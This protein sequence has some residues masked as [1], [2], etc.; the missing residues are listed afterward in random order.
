MDGTMI[1]MWVKQ[2]HQPSPSHHH[3]FI[4]GI[5][6]PFPVMGGRHGIVFATLITI[7]S[8]GITHNYTARL[9]RWDRISTVS[10]GATDRFSD[11]IRWNAAGFLWEDGIYGGWN[12]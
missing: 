10:P 2:C 12:R 9:S 3:K 5:G 4:G 11:R 1:A 7:K 6:L 8:P